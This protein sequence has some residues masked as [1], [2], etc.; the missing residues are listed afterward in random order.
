MMLTGMPS[1]HDVSCLQRKFTG[2]RLQQRAP[3]RQV[4]QRKQLQVCA[5]S[6]VR[7]APVPV[8]DVDGQEVGQAEMALKVAGADTAK[9]LVHRYLVMSQQNKRKVG[10]PPR[11]PLLPARQPCLGPV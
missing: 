6:A 7:S 1:C 2:L 3:V 4:A 10:S 11:T 5:A 8:R 9:G